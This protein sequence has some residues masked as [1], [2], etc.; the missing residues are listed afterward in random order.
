MM[1]LEHAIAK[2]RRTDIDVQSEGRKYTILTFNMEQRL[3]SCTSVIYTVENST[4]YVTT[5]TLSADDNL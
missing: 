3:C 5:A 4:D 2:R 1:F